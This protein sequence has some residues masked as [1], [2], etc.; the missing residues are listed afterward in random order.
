MSYDDI[1]KHNGKPYTGMA[2][3]GT[4][5]WDYPNGIWDELKVSPDKWQ[6]TFNALKK[7]RNT[8]APVNSGVRVG[9]EYHWYIL[10]SQKVKKVDAN[11]YQTFMDGIKLKVGHKRPYWK[12]FSYDYPEQLSEKNRIM[13]ILSDALIQMGGEYQ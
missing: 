10:A 5:H 3:G 11:T 6:F 9:S 7:R 8:H 1:K 13:Q 2:V 4:H 12:E